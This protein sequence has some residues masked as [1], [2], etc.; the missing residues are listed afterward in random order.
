MIMFVT[1]VQLTNALMHPT[2][3][4]QF[5]QE[6]LSRDDVTIFVIS[7]LPLG[8]RICLLFGRYALWS[9]LNPLIEMYGDVL[10]S[11][12]EGSVELSVGRLLDA[13]VVT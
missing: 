8:L 5:Q 11:P 4:T 9:V 13:H 6:L 1:I 3:W 2:Y 10:L 7:N 12:R